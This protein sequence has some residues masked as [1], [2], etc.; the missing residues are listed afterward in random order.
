MMCT[1]ACYGCGTDFVIFVQQTSH[2]RFINNY[3][4]PLKKFLH[5]YAGC[6]H[7]LLANYYGHE[8][9]SSICNLHL[10]KRVKI[11]PYEI[12]YFFKLK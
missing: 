1:T 10:Q 9:V 11:C 2:T 6:L 4:R 12:C 8:G 7:V 5:L 3:V